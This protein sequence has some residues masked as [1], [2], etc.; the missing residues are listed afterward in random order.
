MGR[1]LEEAVE[2]APRPDEC[3]EGEVVES[4]AVAQAVALPADETIV[5]EAGTMLRIAGW[6]S[7]RS[8]SRRPSSVLRTAE[9][10]VVSDEQCAESYGIIAEPELSQAMMCAGFDDG[11]SAFP[12]FFKPCYGRKKRGSCSMISS[13]MTWNSFR[14][15][16]AT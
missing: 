9:V 13:V 14:V 8:G 11:T 15:L 10:P 5:P 2:M 6:G 7:L 4:D 1:Q 12:L 3:A 16:I